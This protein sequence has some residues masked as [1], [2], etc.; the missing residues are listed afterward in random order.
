MLGKLAVCREAAYQLSAFAF[1]AAYSVASMP[2]S[3]K[4]IL[5]AAICSVGHIVTMDDQVHQRCEHWEDQQ[6]EYPEGLGQAALIAVPEQ[7]PND[8]EEQ[9]QIAY[10]DKEKDNRPDCFPKNHISPIKYVF[11]MDR[12]IKRA[13]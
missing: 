5:A 12:L 1:N 13:A 4:R 3:S 6:E 9:N 2:P 10:Q 11:N 7:I 8:L